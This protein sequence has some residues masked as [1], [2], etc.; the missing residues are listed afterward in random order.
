MLMVFA[1]FFVI[2]GLHFHQDSYNYALHEKSS[3]ANSSH[4][5][6]IC[7]FILSAYVEPTVLCYDFTPPAE[8]IHYFIL[9]EQIF[10]TY[11]CSLYL[12]GPPCIS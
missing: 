8:N 7:D 1:S 10:P 11:I 12:R 4:K 6:L 5:C 3:V 9:P 2:K